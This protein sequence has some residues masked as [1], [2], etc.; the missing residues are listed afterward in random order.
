MKPTLYHSG[1]STCSQKVRLALDEKGV[2]YDSVLM[3]LRDGDQ[4]KPEYLQL[5]PR[6]VV[7]T[8]VYG[9]DV[10]I[11]STIIGEY[12]DE[13]FTGPALKPDSPRDRAAMRL[14]TKR[15][16]EVI[17]P[18]V[19]ILTFGIAFR[20]DLLGKSEAELQDYYARMKNPQRSRIYRDLVIH[21]IESDN[22]R[23]AILRFDELLTDM[24][25]TLENQPWLSGD[26]FSLADMGFIPYV[27]RLE[28][29]NLNAWWRNK[30]ALTTWFDRC[31]QRES[32]QTAL[33][34]WFVALSIE[35]M[36]ARGIEA[37]PRIENIISAA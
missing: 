34:D 18:S 28:H 11:E 4:Y 32:Y 14:W 31:K 7:P 29:L 20:H 33:V 12:I 26:T 17:Q 36:R 23:P 37:W 25:E 5:N 13:A 30:P 9:E 27:T 1:I 24:E 15:L 3:Q 6:G 16:D 8:L 10:I 19:V 21:G 2:A 35:S 22:F